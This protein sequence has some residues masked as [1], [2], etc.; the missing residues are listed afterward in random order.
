MKLTCPDCG[1]VLSLA[2]LIEH[3]A[4]RAAIAAALAIPSPIGKHLLQYLKLFKPET[5]QLSMERVASLLNEL[6][7]MIESGRVARKGKTWIAPQEYWVR[8]MAEMFERRRNGSLVPPLKSHGYLLEVISGYSR[9]D[10]AKAE[11]QAEAKRGGQTPVGYHPSH[12]AE[13]TAPRVRAPP[14]EPKPIPADIAAKLKN[15]RR[16]PEEPT[17]EGDTP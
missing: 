7:P 17:E 10:E 14:A 13:P 5:R 8:A 9:A 2:A 15:Y 4:A 1:A 16:K 11:A 6:I 12:H 3:D